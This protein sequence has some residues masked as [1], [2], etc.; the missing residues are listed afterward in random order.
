MEFLGFP[1]GASGKEPTC[2]CRRCKIHRFD[3]W[4]K[5]IPGGG[6][7]NPLLYSCLEISWTEEPGGL[8]SKGWQRVRH[9]WSDLAHKHY[10]YLRFTLWESQYNE[11]KGSFK[12]SHL[13]WTLD[14]CLLWSLGHLPKAQ[15]CS[16]RKVLQIL[17]SNNAFIFLTS[18]LLTDFRLSFQVFNALKLGKVIFFS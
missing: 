5:K 16:N 10:P 17:H 7:G 13:Q 11:G 3:P 2:Q 18:D 6:H 15:V 4:V 8:Q 14:I 12:T 1:G 9:D